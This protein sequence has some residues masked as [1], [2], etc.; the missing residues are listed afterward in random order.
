MLKLFLSMDDAN[1][2]IIFVF[3]MD[4]LHLYKSDRKD[5]CYKSLLLR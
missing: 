5:I 3:S 1:L 2:E 4:T